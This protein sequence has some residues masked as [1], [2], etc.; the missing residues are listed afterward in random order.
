MNTHFSKPDFF[1]APHGFLSAKD[2]ISTGIYESLNCGVG[3]KDDV[4]LVY[5]NRRMAANLIAGRRDIPVVSCYQIHSNKVIEVQEDWRDKRPEADA[6]VTRHPGII[7]GILTADCTPVLF[8]DADAG[9]VGAAHAGWKGALT[10][11][12]ENTVATMEALGA[13]RTRIRAAIGPTIHQNSYEVGT[14]FRQTFM[15]ADPAFVD[16]FTPGKD[17]AH[18]QFDLPGFVEARLQQAGINPVWNTGVDTYKSDNHFSYRRTTHRGEPDYGRQL[19]G[20]MLP[21]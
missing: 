5:E 3:S 14:E 18:F 10:G 21:R 9:V 6:M 2:G 7:L 17:D 20:I 15:D 11:V 16:F 1:S 12:L 19:S 4:G 13:H 8:E